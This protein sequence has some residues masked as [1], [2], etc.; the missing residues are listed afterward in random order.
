MVKRRIFELRISEWGAATPEN[1]IGGFIR[2]HSEK[3][4]FRFAELG[5]ASGTGS[6]AFP[7]DQEV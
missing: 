5:Q 1:F 6:F 4:W 2:V 3:T 7:T